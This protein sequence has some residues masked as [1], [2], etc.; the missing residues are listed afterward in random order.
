MTTKAQIK[1]QWIAAMPTFTVERLAELKA[2][3]ERSIADAEKRC[4]D[5]AAYPPIVKEAQ[6]GIKLAQFCIR[7]IRTEQKARAA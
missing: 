6:A 4:V 2:S 7:A 5:Y 3:Y 1:A